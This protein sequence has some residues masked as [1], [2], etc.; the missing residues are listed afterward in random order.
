MQSLVR[1]MSVDAGYERSHVLTADILL[2]ERAS[3]VQP[4]FLRLHERLRGL[5]GVAAVGL[6]QSTPLT[7]KWTFR[8]PVVVV[9]RARD[10]RSDIAVPGSLVAF[11][12][13]G[14]MGIPILEGRDFTRAEYLQPD[15]LSMI[16]NDVAARVYF[17]GQTAVGRRLHMFGREREIV[18]VV[19]ATR[20]VRLDT[21][22][23][24]QWYQPMFF[25]SSQLVV[26]TT[27]D[28]AAFEAT[29][30]RELLASDPRLI[31]KQVVPL[32][33]IVAASVFERRLATRFL[34]IFAAI[35]LALAVVGLYGMLNFSTIERRREFGVRAALGAQRRD[36]VAMV[37]AQGLGM[38]AIGIAIGAAGSFPLSAAFQH[39]LF[40]VSAHDPL[41]TTIAGALLA[42]SAAAACSIPA[43]RAA[44]VD[45][46][47]ALRA[48]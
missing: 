11:D 23:E 15:P 16:I 44:S 21:P 14:A 5:P 35:A 24:P 10:A 41:T 6:I 27:G 18:G 2:Y 34:S 7:G 3:E 20:D 31:V 13:F 29:L 45:P 42:A 8:E 40:D 30:R 28:P 36:L 43:W 38:T 1:L 19:K 25:G 46:S 33:A 17:P 4:F 22:A 9:G 39:L 37:L 12:Y 32:D 48:D 26:R 47:I